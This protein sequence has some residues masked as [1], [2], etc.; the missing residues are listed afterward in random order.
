[1]E[2]SGLGSNKGYTA[3][4]VVTLVVVASLVA[5]Y[6]V[7]VVWLQGPPEGYSTISLLDANGRAEDYP[8]LLIIGQNNT[9]NVWVNVE[10][11]M[12]ATLPFEVK[13]KITEQV[14]PDFPVNVT[15]QS[16]YS[17]T[18]EN[19]GKWNTTTTTTIDEPGNYMVVYELWAQDTENGALNFTGN[20]CVLN[21][22]VKNQS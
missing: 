3:A 15:E 13:V 21:I 7:W 20:A 6:Y 12:G 10:N 9:F 2:S 1:M 8:E 18:L 17:V 11:H 5:G 19:G 14:N 4:I 16:L 22:E